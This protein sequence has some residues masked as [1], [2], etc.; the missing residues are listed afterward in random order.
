ML[1]PNPSQKTYG[2]LHTENYFLFVGFCKKVESEEIQKVDIYLDDKLID[3]VLADKELQKI[4]DIYDIEGFG[5][6]YDLDEK[7]IGPKGTI[8]FKNH[9]TKENLQN[10]PYELVDKNNPQ[11]NESRFLYSL[12]QDI[13]KEKIKDMYCP[14]SI[15]FLATEENLGDED[16]VGY[17]KE[18]ISKYP[19][20]NIKSFCFNKKQKIL[21]NSI[22]GDKID[23]SIIDNIMVLINNIEI[24]IFNTLPSPFLRKIFMIIKYY[25]ELIGVIQFSKEMDTHLLSSE[26]T[27]HPAL[28][29]PKAYGL[30]KNEL[31]KYNNNFYRL[32]YSKYFEKSYEDNMSLHS[33]LNIESIL[34]FINDRQF[35]KHMNRINK[36]TMNILNIKV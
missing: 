21:A 36:I 10:S 1:V 11:F 23:F 22:F 35:K 12:T 16:F 34:Y 19:D 33:L 18:L 30:D 7:Y 6:T 17:I 4:E 13:V 29:N 27:T 5:F 32:I 15:G 24:F 9:I 28:S 8:S 31:S 26:T 20:I 14:N 25:C 3:T 2:V